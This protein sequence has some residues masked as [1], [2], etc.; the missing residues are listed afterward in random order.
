MKNHYIS[1]QVLPPN[2]FKSGQAWNELQN[3]L[4]GFLNFRIA[5]MGLWTLSSL[6]L[7]SSSFDY[8]RKISPMHRMFAE[9]WCLEG[10]IHGG[11]GIRFLTRAGSQSLP[12]IKCVSLRKSPSLNFIFLIYKMCMVTLWILDIPTGYILRSYE[13][14]NLWVLTDNIISHKI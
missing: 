5:N 10:P 3:L 2:E 11:N 1:G 14:T 12:F 13:T 4:W 9:C 8:K 7:Y 6:S